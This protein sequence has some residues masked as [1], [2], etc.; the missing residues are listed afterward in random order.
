MHSDFFFNQFSISSFSQFL[1]SFLITLFFLIIKKQHPRG[2]FRTFFFIA[3]TGV[4]LSSFLSTSLFVW[5]SKYFIT[6]QYI[7][8]MLSVSLITQFVYRF[9]AN[10]FQS[11]SR[12]VSILSFSITFFVSSYLIYSIIKNQFYSPG[13]LQ[14]VNAILL[15]GFFWAMSVSTRY[16]LI[17]VLKSDSWKGKIPSTGS[18]DWVKLFLFAFWDV[19]RGSKSE[20]YRP[21]RE[22]SLLVF[23]LFVGSLPSVLNFLY[24]SSQISQ[25]TN[26]YLSN[27]FYLVFLF[28]F[29]LA[30]FKLSPEQSSINRKIITVSI[31]TILVV[32]SIVG[33]ATMSTLTRQYDTTR[34]TPDFKTL[35]FS[36][37]EDGRYYV[38]SETA[39]WRNPNGRRLYL[40]DANSV[41]MLLPFPFPFY[42]TEYRSINVGSNGILSFGSGINSYH[43]TEFY[44]SNPKIAGLF[45]DLNPEKGGMV[46]VHETDSTA[47]FSWVQV[48]DF[49][50][51]SKNTFQIVLHRDGS[52]DLTYYGIS[53]TFPG[54]IGL[55]AGTQTNQQETIRFDKDLPVIVPAGES[56]YEDYFRDQRAYIHEGA[57]VF[58]FMIL[59]STAVAIIIFPYF[60]RLTV[61][62]PL[63]TLLAGVRKVNEGDL[64]VQVIV[65]D[66]DEIGFLTRSF[67]QMI[68]SVR[69]AK[70]EELLFIQKQKEEELLQMELQ[71]Q[72]KELEFARNLQMDMLPAAGLKIPGL[73]FVGKM[74]PATEVGGDYYD[75]IHIA[76]RRYCVA[77]GDATGHGV[78]AGL[79]VGMVKMAIINTIRSYNINLSLEQLMIN[80]NTALMES[81]HNRGIGMG[82][83]LMIIDLDQMSAQIIS[84]G[85]PY[86]FF[87]RKSE[88]TFSILELTGPP[89][90]MIADIELSSVN[91]R[92]NSGDVF[93]F[94]SD[95]FPERLN[96]EDVLFFE[97]QAFNSSVETIIKSESDLTTITSRLFEACDLFADGLENDDD[98]TSLIVRVE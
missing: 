8:L 11:E 95:G 17:P 1:L 61:T 73:E 78:A 90:G 59:F 39:A 93:L 34:K 98:M 31:L 38:W 43:Y 41:W 79:V 81:I 32:L 97:D 68:E 4:F 9:P 26:L 67:N 44:R 33:S 72:S 91:I 74:R 82:L 13:E 77:I 48:P 6:S 76:E 53:K 20:I 92:L 24:H 27:F 18:P 7:L 63:K 89:L 19:I 58:I 87:Y 62:N 80:L 14:V 36:P 2:W 64:T 57:F 5:W 30:Y 70:E 52:I 37:A 50:S 12:F 25:T 40:R 45:K 60:F 84:S 22:L 3:I 71:R 28:L 56:A 21:F 88:D 16:S 86:P 51:N 96:P 46:L 49:G 54:F 42:G 65:K 75:L 10:Y 85:M 94:I 23:I 66:D 69:H 35:H 29:I 55:D 15:C 83:C 47:T